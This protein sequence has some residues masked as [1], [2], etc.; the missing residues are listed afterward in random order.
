MIMRMSTPDSRTECDGRCGFPVA[1]DVEDHE[2]IATY[3]GLPPAPAA[4]TYTNEYER[5]IMDTFVPECERILRAA[6]S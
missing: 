6:I 2:Q 1:H 3:Y 4:R 5:G